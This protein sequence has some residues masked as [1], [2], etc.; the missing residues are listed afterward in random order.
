MNHILLYFIYFILVTLYDAVFLNFIILWFHIEDTKVFRNCFSDVELYVISYFI[1]FT[2]QEP[3]ILYVI[4]KDE[5]VNNVWIIRSI[6]YIHV[7]QLA[8]FEKIMEEAGAFLLVFI[9]YTTNSTKVLQGK[10]IITVIGA[11]TTVKIY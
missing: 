2:L 1:L 3:K 7:L 11:T 4:L 10:N 8:A 6:S 9:I 5:W